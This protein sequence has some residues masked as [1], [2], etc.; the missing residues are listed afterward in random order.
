MRLSVERKNLFILDVEKDDLPFPDNYFELLTMIDVLEHLHFFSID[1]LLKEMK[2][3]LKPN[4]YICLTL[5]TKEAEKKDV[6][7]INL[8]PKPFWIELFIEYNFLSAEKE[9][10]LLK[11]KSQKYLWDNKLYFIKL[12]KKLLKNMPPSTRLGKFLLRTGKIGRILRE[13]FWFYNYF[14]RY[15]H[16]Y[17]NEKMILFRFINP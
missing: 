4:G 15:N 2:R 7:H 9:K 14:F 10:K 16:Q 11:K 13:T 17:F 5:P 6:T 8:H 12:Y 3:V 1:H